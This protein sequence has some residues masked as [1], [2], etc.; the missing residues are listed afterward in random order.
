MLA[1]TRPLEK[2]GNVAIGLLYFNYGNFEETNIFGEATGRE[3]S[4]S[5]FALA[6]SLANELGEGFDYGL[7]LKFIY[8]SLDTY[9]ASGLA[10]D[11]GL[12]YTAPFLDNAQLGF[13]ISNLGFLMSNYTSASSDKMP[14]YLRFGFAK[15]LAH[16]PLLFTA[17]LNDLTLSTGNSADIFKRFSIGGEFDISEFVKFRLGYDNG[18]NRNVKPLEGRS[19]GGVSAGVGIFWRNFRLDYAFTTYSDLGSLNRLAISGFLK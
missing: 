1:Y 4:A 13:S 6:F 17:S 8:S 2:L 18:V 12:F 7:N 14:L 19:F 10:L 3:F 15:R 5:E 9:N 16:L 11:A